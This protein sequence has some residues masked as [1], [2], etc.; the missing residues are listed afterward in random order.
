MPT[1]LDNLR[2]GILNKDWELVDAAYIALTG[3]SILAELEEVIKPVRK[4]RTPKARSK[5]A[6]ATKPKKAT[7]PRTSRKKPP[8]AIVEP[9]R[10]QNDFSM[11]VGVPQ[12]NN[13]D[14]IQAKLEQVSL[15]KKN[16]FIDDRL[17]F[18]T[19][20]RMSKQPKTSR[21]GPSRPPIKV[22]NMTCTR[23]AKPNQV[24]ENEIIEDVSYICRDCLKGI[25]SHRR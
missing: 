22:L 21:T 11:P 1:P 17:D 19:E 7:K 25:Y 9:Q 12:R 4:S 3:I 10:D 14:K 8:E 16:V 23:C 20:R 6:K 2:Q 13:E 5:P 24:M 15:R 18:N